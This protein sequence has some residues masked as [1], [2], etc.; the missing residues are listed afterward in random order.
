MQLQSSWARGRAAAILIVSAMTCDGSMAQSTAPAEKTVEV[1][2]AA[3]I[4]LLEGDVTIFDA[5]KK[6]R[7][8][9]VSDHLSEG[10][11]IVT[12]KD[13]EL[14]LEMEDGGFLSVR[15]NTKMRIV[16][17]QAKGEDSDSAIFGLLQGS[18]RSV[19]GWLGKYNRANYTV[20]T[21]TATV[22]VRG[23]DHEPY[24]IPAGSTEGDPGTYDRV[25]AGGT[26]IKNAAG[27]TDIGVN[28]SGFVSHGKTDRPR[29]LK[30]HPK[31]FR[32]ARN[33]H[34]FKAKHAEVQSRIEKRREERRSAIRD[35]LQQRKAGAGGRAGTAAQQRQD[36]RDAGRNAR[37]AQR[38]ERKEQRAEKVQ[39]AKAARE[40][41]DAHE[42]QRVHRDREP[43]ERR[44]D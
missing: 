5:S 43:R 25:H 27:R 2:I 28:Q 12:G 17:Y 36:A 24:V 40:A 34:V 6:K 3:R 33:D 26:Y 41:K 22:G 11:S 14:H 13:G 32:A 4:A 9:R 1:N 35:K 18:F 8:V 10:E 29:V 16:K 7:A 37:E 39:D 20:R 23:T 44:R 42:K 31:F 21:P 15:P 19:T 38:T 30:E